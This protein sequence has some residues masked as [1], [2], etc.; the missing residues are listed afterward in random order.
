MSASFFWRA[1][2]RSRTRRSCFF[3]AAC[4]FTSRGFRIYGIAPFALPLVNTTTA[5]AR[6]NFKGD[7]RLT[8]WLFPQPPLTLAGGFQRI[9]A[10]SE[11]AGSSSASIDRTCRARR[12]SSSR[13]IAPV[14]RPKPP[15]EVWQLATYLQVSD[16][17]FGSTSK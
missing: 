17:Y 1:S 7:T 13:A 3:R 15:S 14:A 12:L 10:R 2:L 6:P 11:P 5:D 16:E 4:F 9:P 8:R